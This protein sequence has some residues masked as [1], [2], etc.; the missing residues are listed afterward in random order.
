[1]TLSPD[2]AELFFR[3]YYT[4]L[5]GRFTLVKCLKS[6]AVVQGGPDSR[7]Y[8]VLGLRIPIGDALGGAPLPLLAEMALLPFRGRIVYDGILRP[9][10]IHFGGGARRSGEQSVAGL[11]KEMQ[12]VR[13]AATR[14]ENLMIENLV[15]R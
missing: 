7:H 12:K 5:S 8:R 15:R 10:R 11:D 4:F 9:Y 3:V 2:E 6:G 13:R 14:F 1:M